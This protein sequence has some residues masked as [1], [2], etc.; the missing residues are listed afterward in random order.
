M[1]S[2]RPRKPPFDSTAVDEVHPSKIR[3]KTRS[4]KLTIREQCVCGFVRA[5][6]CSDHPELE[7][8]AEA[9]RFWQSSEVAPPRKRGLDQ[10]AAAD[11]CLPLFSERRPA[12]L[13]VS[14]MRGGAD[15]AMTKIENTGA[16]CAWT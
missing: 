15:S 14:R 3:N 11:T 8:R 5:A 4:E 6:M 7:L 9:K 12:R 16:E 10:I 13:D 2:G 1:D